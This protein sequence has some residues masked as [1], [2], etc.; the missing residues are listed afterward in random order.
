MRKEQNFKNDM[1]TKLDN[2]KKVIK[3]IPV[4]IAGAAIRM[5]DANFSAQGFVVGGTARPKWKKRKTET[6]L[7]GGRRILYGTGN[8]QENVKTKTTPRQVSI[9]VDLSK[10]PYAKMHNE[11]GRITQYVRPF[12]RGRK[13]ASNIRTRKRVLTGGSQVKGFTRRINMPK[14]QFIG[15]SPDIFKI[16][17]KDIK[18]E[19]DKIF[20]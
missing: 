14:R 5:K 15:F 9:G 8:L 4:Y 2:V 18:A 3:K 11:G 17:E 7:T 6:K 1:R 16:V 12:A 10:V 20:K 19:L 13:V